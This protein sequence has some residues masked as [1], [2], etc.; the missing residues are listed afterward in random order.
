MELQEFLEKFFPDYEEK[1]KKWVG[2]NCADYS[3]EKYDNIKLLSSDWLL[4]YS[5]IFPEALQNFA[6]RICK[7][8]R[9]ICKDAYEFCEI[10]TFED[11]MIE[12]KEAP[13][14]VIEEI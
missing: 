4:F 12:I 10:D 3:I 5:N 8:Q 6:D 13:K 7:K 2:D 14:P 11:A 1:L 9:E